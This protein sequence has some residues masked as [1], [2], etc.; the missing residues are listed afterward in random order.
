MIIDSLTIEALLGRALT[1][2]EATRAAELV[3]LAAGVVEGAIP[4]FTIDPGTETFEIFP[5]ERGF[6]WT[7]KYPVTDLTIEGVSPVKVSE[8]G[9]VRYGPNVYGD[10]NTFYPSSTPW[11]VNGPSFWPSTLPVSVTYSFGFT[12]PTRDII[13]VVASMVVA[14][15]TR[16]TNGM[17]VQ[18]ESLGAYSVTYGDWSVQQAAQGLVLPPGAL[19]RWRRKETTVPLVR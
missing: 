12:D 10:T 13:T 14:A 19:D 7:P 2:D 17:G 8:K 15:I 18:A 6:F 5:E 1:T 11:L 9:F 16:Q 4:G 3:D